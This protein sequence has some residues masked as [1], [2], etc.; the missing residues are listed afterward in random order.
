M[1]KPTSKPRAPNSPKPAPKTSEAPAREATA[2]ALKALQGWAALQ[3]KLFGPVDQFMALTGTMP[4]SALLGP[5]FE[6]W[7]AYTNTVAQKVG[8]N[9]DWLSYFESE[10]D[11]GATP[12]TVSWT[13]LDGTKEELELA[14]LEQLLYVIT[15]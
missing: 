14:T 11:M 4:D 12:R 2:E 7:A 3:A 5:V 1:T 10:C 8:D 13:A 15:S 6:L 9:A